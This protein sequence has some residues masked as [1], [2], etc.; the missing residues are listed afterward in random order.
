[1][2][3]A[4]GFLT[5]GGAETLNPGIGGVQSRTL[6]KR[7]TA[8]FGTNMSNRLPVDSVAAGRSPSSAQSTAVGEHP[9]G[10]NPMMVWVGMLIALAVL[11]VAYKKSAHLQQHVGPLTVFGMVV[12]LFTAVIVFTL[13]KMVFTRFQVPGLTQLVQSL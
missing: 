7:F 11:I 1:M 9:A 4:R 2:L 6:P 5:F 3:T 13:G 8:R 12:F 10:G